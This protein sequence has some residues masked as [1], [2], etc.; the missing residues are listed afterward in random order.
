MTNIDMNAIT[1]DHAQ[2]QTIAEDAYFGQKA[3][4]Y[5]TGF[6]RQAMRHTW[7]AAIRYVLTQ[8]QEWHTLPTRDAIL[9]LQK[10]TGSIYHPIFNDGTPGLVTIW[11]DCPTCGRTTTDSEGLC[12]TCGYDHLA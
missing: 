6:T 8:Q 3:P 5:G 4:L 1:A 9:E 7:R 10:G 12:H 11:A 2:A